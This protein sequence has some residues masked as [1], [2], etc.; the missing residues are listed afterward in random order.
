MLNVLCF[1]HLNFFSF[2]PSIFSLAIRIPFFALFFVISLSLV[3]LKRN[4]SFVHAL[5]IYFVWHIPYAYINGLYGDV[6]ATKQNWRHNASFHIHFTFVGIHKN[7]NKNRPINIFLLFEWKTMCAM[8]S[9]F[10]CFAVIYECCFVG[11][12]CILNI[13][14]TSTYINLMAI[15]SGL[16]QPKIYDTI[17][18]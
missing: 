3:N 8:T 18:F 6:R 12:L 11:W 15:R 17:F 7:K 1:R 9:D 16:V 10:I 4:V 14:S 2:F 13:F 5:H